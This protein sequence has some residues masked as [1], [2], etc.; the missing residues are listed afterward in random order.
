MTTGKVVTVKYG[1]G[2]EISRGF[3]SL[4]EIKNDGNV[5]AV[6]GYGDNVDFFVNGAMTTSDAD[7][8]ILQDG[9]VVSIQA[10]TSTKSVK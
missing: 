4:G 7:S 10:K 9:D 5:K 1:F 3:D 2:N 8:L 6:L